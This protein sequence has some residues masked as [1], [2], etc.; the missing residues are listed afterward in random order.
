MVPSC[1]DEEVCRLELLLSGAR[2][3]RFL[4]VPVKG[5]VTYKGMSCN[6]AY[7]YTVPF[8]IKHS[9][10]RNLSKAA[11]VF[12]IVIVIFRLVINEVADL[13]LAKVVEYCSLAH[14]LQRYIIKLQY[15]PV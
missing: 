1:V 9:Q 4:D 8:C 7:S 2:E 11:V 5:R 12:S 3:Y 13:Q 6:A 15:H 10:F 14:L